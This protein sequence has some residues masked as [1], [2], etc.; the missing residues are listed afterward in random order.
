MLFFSLLFMLA[1]VT[2]AAASGVMIALI[3]MASGEKNLRLALA[4]RNWSPPFRKWA[5]YG[6]AGVIVTLLGM[7]M[8]VIAT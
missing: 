7:V 1:G 8:A 3:I 4:P 2:L 6:G 5:R